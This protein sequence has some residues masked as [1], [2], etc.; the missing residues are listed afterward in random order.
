M[1]EYAPMT[2]YQGGKHMHKMKEG[3]RSD[4]RGGKGGMKRSKRRTIAG[5]SKRVRV[6]ASQTGYGGEELA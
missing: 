1:A 5:K 6:K 2:A 4:S 3:S